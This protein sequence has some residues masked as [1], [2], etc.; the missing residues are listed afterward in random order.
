MKK[1]PEALSSLEYEKVINWFERESKKRKR[2]FFSYRNAFIVKLLLLTG[3]RASELLALSIDDFIPMRSQE[4][5]AMHKIKILGKGNKERYVYIAQEV[6]EEELLFLKEYLQKVEHAN[7][8]NNQKSSDAKT[9]KLF[10]C[11]TKE[12]RVLM[13]SELY[14]TINSFLKQ[15]GIAKKGVHMLRHSFGKH[16]VSKNINLST[17]KDLMGHENIQTTMIYARSDEESMI[18]A[19]V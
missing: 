5:R 14:L 7:I 6:I 1:D 18:R 15:R 12:G 19:V 4:N 17:I 10:L 13:R 16:M 2:S 9:S 8:S 3:I 11:S